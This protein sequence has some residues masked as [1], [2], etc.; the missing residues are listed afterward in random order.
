LREQDIIGQIEAARR[1]YKYN[2]ELVYEILKTVANSQSFFY[3]VRKEVI[4]SLQKMEIH[5]FN[6]FISHEMFLMKIYNT[7]HIL[8]GDTLVEFY[9]ENDFSNI[10]EHFMDRY[11]LKAISKCKEEMLPLRPD[12]LKDF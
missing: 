5:T 10:L 2:D 7:N 6:K 12:C 11:F 1:L 3:K 4:L 8:S 9:K